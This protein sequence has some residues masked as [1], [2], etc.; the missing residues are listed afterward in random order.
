MASNTQT[1]NPL[2]PK[3]VG[4]G[5]IILCYNKTVPGRLLPEPG[6]AY[7]C[8]LAATVITTITMITEVKKKRH[9]QNSI[10]PSKCIC[11]ILGLDPALAN[12]GC[13]QI[14]LWVILNICCLISIFH[15]L[16]EVCRQ[17]SHRFLSVL[18]VFLDQLAS[19]F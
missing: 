6:D 15:E 5:Q 13:M 17:W 1:H 3:R 19:R 14:K 12:N 11:H 2:L 9:M 7:R 4:Q 18:G 8:R 16:H 10:F